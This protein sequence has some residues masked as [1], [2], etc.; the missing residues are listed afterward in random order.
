MSDASSRTVRTSAL[1]GSVE[2]EILKR[3]VDLRDTLLVTHGTAI[4]LIYLIHTYTHK[5]VALSKPKISKHSTIRTEKGQGIKAGVDYS[6][7]T[8][9]IPVRFAITSNK[10][11]EIRGPE[12][13]DRLII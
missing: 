7:S 8:S 12:A 9:E 4:P 5:Q 3:L 13:K 10:E 6:G 1:P 11:R 2:D